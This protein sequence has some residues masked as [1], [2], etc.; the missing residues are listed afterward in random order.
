MTPH[1]GMTPKPTV[2]MTP[3]RTPLR[4][5]LNINT[6][7][8]SVD[9]TDPAYTKHLVGTRIGLSSVGLVAWVGSESGEIVALRPL[10]RFSDISVT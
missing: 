4:D 3:G 5:K 9:Y 8:G 1:S 2:A 7:D 10:P 6:E